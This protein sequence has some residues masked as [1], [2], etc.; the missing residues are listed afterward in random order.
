MFEFIDLRDSGPLL[1]AMSGHAVI[2]LDTEFMREKTFFAE[3]CLIQIAMPEQIF[4]V[5]PMVDADLRPFWDKLM[6]RSWVLH[7]G[8]QDMEILFAAAAVMP[9]S[10][11]DTQVAAA[12]VGHPP[13]IGYASLVAEL[14]GVTLAKSHTRADWSK[15]PLPQSVIEYAAEDVAYL[16]PMKEMLCDTL[17]RLHRLEW[18]EQDS[19]D[20]LDET[21]YRNDPSSAINRVK[22]AKNLRGPARAAAARFATWR[23][24]EALRRNR[25]RQWILRDAVLLEMAVKRPKTSDQLAGISGLAGRTVQRSADLFLDLIAAA[26]Q[27]G[28]DYVPPPR[29]NERQKKQLQKALSLAARRADELGVSAEILVPRK[30]LSSALFGDRQ[31]RV[32][33]GWRRAV[34]GEELQDI[35]DRAAPQET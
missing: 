10:V 24:E 32:F 34:I 30:E 19:A 14:C 33:R 25:P 29:P 4:C 6:D 5:D 11:F 2:G 28:S 1:Q 21:L 26:E 17:D 20:L 8:R 7:A 18:A 9:V 16:L 27:D 35:F 3:L 22:G 15:R 31:S 12:L 23:E 13:Q